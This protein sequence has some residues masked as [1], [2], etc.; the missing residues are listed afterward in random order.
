MYSETINTITKTNNTA[1][2][3]AADKKLVEVCKTLIPRMSD[4][5]INVIENKHKDSALRKVI[6]NDMDEVGQMLIPRT[7]DDTMNVIDRAGNTLLIT[8]AKKGMNA[9][10]I[11]LISRMPLLNLLF[12]LT[13]LEIRL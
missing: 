10:C 13:M 8:A 5:A 12:T 4:E 3:L 6:R 9:V 11:L 2:T 7:S 1:L